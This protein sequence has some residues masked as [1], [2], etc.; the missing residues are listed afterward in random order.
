ML[1]FL[2]NGKL[3]LE[4]LAENLY[5]RAPYENPKEFEFVISRTNRQFWILCHKRGVR[6]SVFCNGGSYSKC[7]DTPA[8]YGVG[9][10]PWES[11]DFEIAV[12]DINGD[13]AKYQFLSTDKNDYVT[14]N[15]T[16][17]DLDEILAHIMSPKPL[18]VFNKEKN[19]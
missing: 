2:A 3:Q 9:S 7:K 10:L 1:K 14:K 17:E 5:K 4:G 19:R 15:G 8:V 13:P 18:W 16:W 6:V 12:G 11:E